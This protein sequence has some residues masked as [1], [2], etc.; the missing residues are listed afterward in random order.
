[1]CIIICMS[2]YRRANWAPAKWAAEAGEICGSDHSSYVAA[3]QKPVTVLYSEELYPAATEKDL[4][5]IRF[6]FFEQIGAS[7][8]SHRLNGN[9]E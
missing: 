4:P 8:G 3:P 9:I 6:S 5:K 2:T 7:I 1:M